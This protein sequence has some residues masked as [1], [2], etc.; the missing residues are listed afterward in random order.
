MKTVN[1]IV[2]AL[3]VLVG[4]TAAAQPHRMTPQE[5]TDQLEKQLAL[6]AEQKQKVLVLFTEQEKEMKSIFAEA[7][8]DR[9]A[10]RAAMQ[11]RRGEH[12]R[13]LKAILTV[14]QYKEY[15]KIRSQRGPGRMEPP[16]EPP[17]GK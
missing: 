8:G 10:M 13:K 7:G 11:K 5:R 3:V 1:I 6:T 4:A 17:Q 12:D 15:E 16:G 2:L 9:D 14:Q